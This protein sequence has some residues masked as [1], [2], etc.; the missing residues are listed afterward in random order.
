VGRVSGYFAGERM[1][2]LRFQFLFLGTITVIGGSL[3]IAW[4]MMSASRPLLPPHGYRG[5]DDISILMGV[6][7]LFMAV[8][9]FGIYLRQKDTTTQLGRVSLYI[10]VFGSILAFIGTVMITIYGSDFGLVPVFFGGGGILLLVGIGLTGASIIQARIL[11]QWSGW[12]LVGSVIFGLTGDEN[13]ANITILLTLGF[14]WIIVGAILSLYPSKSDQ[15]P[16]AFRASPTS[17][18]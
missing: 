6:A 2:R 13:S 17:R 14:A 3:W 5:N 10:G 12:L 1:K 15:E 16:Q 9:M 8:G 11:P 4:V 18:E 7:M